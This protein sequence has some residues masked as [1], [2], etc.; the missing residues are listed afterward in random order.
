MF[1]G[2]RSMSIL[3]SRQK[4][5]QEGYSQS[6]MHRRE[7]STGSMRASRSPPFDHTVSGEPPG[8]SGV[9]PESPNTA[10]PR[11][12][13]IG[14]GLPR[15]TPSGQVI[16]S[17]GINVEGETVETNAFLLLE[18]ILGNPAS[19]LSRINFFLGSGVDSWLSVENQEM[20]V[21]VPYSS[22]E[23]C[24]WYIARV[25]VPQCDIQSCFSFV[26]LSVFNRPIWVSDI[27]SDARTSPLFSW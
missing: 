13:S 4:Q 23:A 10:A 9:I 15:E 6:S 7:A 5:Q 14:R 25:R 16:H 18:N 24:S 11:S 19:V 1:L 26:P 20:F 27:A 22:W 12:S 3:L 21:F 17:I 2:N 8:F